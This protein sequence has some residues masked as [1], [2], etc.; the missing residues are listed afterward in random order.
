MT[1]D[2]AANLNFLAENNARHVWHPM[3]DPKASERDPPLIVARG[4]GTRV[5]DADGT[6]Y[7]DLMGGL[8]NVNVGHN[9]PKVKRAIAAQLDRLAYYNTFAGFSNPPSIELSAKLVEMLRP[10]GMVRVMF[11]TGGSDANE[12]A[13]KLA[14]QYWKIMDRPEKVKVFSLKSA[15]H[16]VQFGGL[17]ASGGIVWRRAY[18]PLMPGFHQVDTPDPY[19]NPWSDDPDELAE[20]CGGILDREIAHQGADTVAAF[21][22]EPVQGAGGVIVP[23]ASYWPLLREICDRR[24]VLLIADEVVTGFGRT[25]SMFGARGWGVKPDIMTFAKGINSGYVPLSAT[26]VNARVAAAWDRDHPLAPIMHGY[27]GS[28]HPLACAAALA[29]LEIVEDDDLAGNAARVGAR[30]LDRLRARL[31]ARRPVGDV[32]GK[33][34][35]IGIEFVKD[36]ETREPLA[37]DDPFLRAVASGCRDRGVLVRCQAHRIVISPPLTFSEAEADRAAAALDEAVADNG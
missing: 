1:S 13:F 22:A 15:Y 3:T 17:S 30:F 6:E 25:G 11:G 34:L 20:I 9:H 19:R 27:T 32:R 16:G 10:E 4:D 33:G 28:G 21:I 18:E 7:L 8:W 2:A 23:P 24:D 29:C 5:W 12:T 37:P 36:R 35:M 31:G 14:R 26:A